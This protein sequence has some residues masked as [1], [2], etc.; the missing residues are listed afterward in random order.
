MPLLTKN[1]FQPPQVEPEGMDE[2]EYDPYF[3]DMNQQQDTDNSWLLT[4][5]GLLGTA[6]VLDSLNP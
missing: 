4:A 6:I 1:Q 3:E 5:A 2:D